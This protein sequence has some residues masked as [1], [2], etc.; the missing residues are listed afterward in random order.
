MKTKLI[1]TI[2]VII[3]A[4]SIGITYGGIFSSNDKYDKKEIKSRVSVSLQPVEV[5]MDTVILKLT[6][7]THSVP[8]ENIDLKKN[9]TLKT[10]AG[11]IHPVK[12]PDLSSHHGNGSVVFKLKKPLKTITVFVRNVPDI[13]KRV[14]KW[15]I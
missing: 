14:F 7:N 6:L 3:A 8:L 15:D 2:G 12:V 10:D 5:T 9:I 13:E 1:L 11:E 4:V